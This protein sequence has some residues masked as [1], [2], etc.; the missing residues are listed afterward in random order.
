MEEKLELRVYG[1]PSLR[2]LV[3]LPGLHGDWT[4][5]GGFRAAVAGRVR[6]VEMTYPRTLTWSL[7]DYAAAIEEELSKL[8]ITH[9]WLL[10]ESF[11]SQ[12]MWKLIANGKFRAQ[13]AV[14]AG[15]FV[16]YPAQWFMQLL[17]KATGHGLS[18]LLVK[19]MFGYARFARYRYRRSPQTLATLDE[20][21]ARRRR[22]QDREAAEH[23]LQL[24]DGNDP[25]KIA[26]TAQIPIF[27]LTGIL[28]PIVPWPATRRWLKRNCPALRDYKIVRRADHNVLSTGTKESAKWILEWMDKFT[29][30][31]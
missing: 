30:D 11:G 25:R 26:M 28:D 23:R 29:I 22:P 12:P 19:I 17:E 7:D 6:F 8:G 5:I 21:L 31:D 27:G 24:V 18:V 1:D 20:F 13:G 10:G 4:I 14:L 16:R 2:A 3:Y 9:G 15:G